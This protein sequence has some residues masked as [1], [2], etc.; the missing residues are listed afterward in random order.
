MEE[1]KFSFGSMPYTV[2]AEVRLLGADVLV[3]LS[4]GTKPHIGSIAVAHPRPS[5]TDEKI[6]SSTSSVYNFL[7]HKDHVIAQRVAEMLSSR[8]DKNVVAVAGFHID[9]I[10]QEGISRVVENCDELAK[11]IYNEIVKW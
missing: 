8:L 2:H 11:E 10:T 1:K 3:I 4:G 9:K 6:V 5:L 7:G